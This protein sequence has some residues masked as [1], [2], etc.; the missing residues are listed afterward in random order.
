MPTKVEGKI[1]NPNSIFFNTY[2]SYYGY[3]VEKL[4]VNFSDADTGIYSLEQINHLYTRITK[5]KRE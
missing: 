3:S 4:A 5:E 2:F 1:G